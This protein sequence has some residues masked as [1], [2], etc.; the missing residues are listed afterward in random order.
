MGKR[1][2]IVILL[3]LLSL[4]VLAQLEPLSTQYMY[5]QLM[6]N[7]GYAGVRN[8][9]SV[10]IMARHQWMGIDG[11]PVNYNVSVHS[12]LNKSM[13]SLGGALNSYQVGPTQNNRVNFYYSYLIRLRYNMFMSMG[14]TAITNHYGFKGLDWKLIDQE[15]PDFVGT[16]QNSF[17]P[18]FGAG[19]FIYSPSFY[20]GFSIPQFL[21]YGFKNKDS[22]QILT[23][24]K[25]HYYISSGYG[26]ALNKEFYLKPS[27]LVRFV[28]NGMYSIDANVEMLYSEIFSVGISYRINNSIAFI[29]GFRI[30]DNINMHYSYDLST[31]PSG[32]S[33]GSHEITLS[34]DTNKILRRN[35]NRMFS[36][37]KKEESGAMRSIRYF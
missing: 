28:E 18:N 35:R 24:V 23:E 32:I 10:N 19:L 36:K 2:Y 27:T 11:A 21:A 37:K 25:R 33:K 26:F 8:A 31:A 5:S 14:V 13:V 4:R 20:F 15:D 17:K 3:L 12:P 7:P 34:F 6:I 16:S 9:F 22:D 29:G 30:S 1:S